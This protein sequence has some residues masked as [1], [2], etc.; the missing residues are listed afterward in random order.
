MF[1][2]FLSLF[3]VTELLS[4][5][6]MGF[7]FYFHFLFLSF[8]IVITCHWTVSPAFFTLFTFFILACF[9]LFFLLR[10][11]SIYLIIPC[12]QNIENWDLKWQYFWC[13]PRLIPI[14]TR[15]CWSTKIEYIRMAFNIL[16]NERLWNYH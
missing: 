7:F 9:L 13:T 5:F 11:G 8:T 15:C 4:L 16:L 1:P 12:A 2:F 3:K 6:F 10:W 14:N